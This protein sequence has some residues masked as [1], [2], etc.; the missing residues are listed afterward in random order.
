[1]EY[2]PATKRNRL[3][4]HP[5][6]WMNLQSCVEWKQLIFKGLH[7]VW[8]HIYITFLKWQNYGNGEQVSSCQGL[9]RRYGQWGSRCDY[10]WATR[11]LLEVMQMVCTLT[12]SMSISP[13]LTLPSLCFPAHSLYPEICWEGIWPRT[14]FVH[15]TKRWSYPSHVQQICEHILFLFCVISWTFSSSSSSFCILPSG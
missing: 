6:T 4:I 11:G 15:G 14:W 13:A 5:T 12:T 8:F 2:Y 3:L 7:T 9:R 10:K 1:M